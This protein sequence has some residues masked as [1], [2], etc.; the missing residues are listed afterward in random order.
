M[1]VFYFF[2]FWPPCGTWEFPGQGSDP[3]CR[4]HLGRSCSNAGFLTHCARLGI[5]PVSQHSQ[6]T[7]NPIVPEQELLPVNILSAVYMSAQ[8]GPEE[9]CNSPPVPLVLLG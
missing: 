1:W 7:A 2:L 4:C 8:K 3:R 5:K 9:A 6:D